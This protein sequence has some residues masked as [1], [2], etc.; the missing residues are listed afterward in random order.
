MKKRILALALAA[1]TAFSMFGASLSV[2]AAEA[3]NA[4]VA[5][6]ID[7]SKY[8]ET[9]GKDTYAVYDE[10]I[11]DMEA[12][13]A[14][15]VE[16]ET[17]AVD[18]TKYIYSYDYISSSWTSFQNALDAALEANADTSFAYVAV[19]TNLAEAVKTAATGLKVDTGSGYDASSLRISLLKSY[20]AAKTAVNGL[21][22]DDYDAATQKALAT[23]KDLFAGASTAKRN[24][25]LVYAVAEY[26]NFVENAGLA[27]IN[28]DLYTAIDALI[29]KAEKVLEYRD[30]YK[31]T[32][33]ANR[34]FATLEKKLEA[35]YEVSGDYSVTNSKL[36]TVKE[37]L[38]AALTAVARYGTAAS[39]ATRDALAAAIAKAD[40]CKADSGYVTTGTS[41]AAKA[42][43]DA[44]DA[45]KAITSAD[46]EH[47]VAD[48]TDA[49]LDAIANLKVNAA[50]GS[51]V[52]AAQ[53]K[54][55]EAGMFDLVETDYTPSSWANYEDAM[56]QY[57][58]AVTKA[59][60]DAA[61]ARLLNETGA[62]KPVKL[63]KVSTRVQKNEF[64][65][66]YKEATA[67][68]KDTKDKSLAAVNSFN[69]AVKAAETFKTAKLNSATVSE[70]EAQISA[71]EAAIKAYKENKVVA[72]YEGWAYDKGVWTFYVKGEAV[73]G[74]N[75][76]DN[77]WYYM[78]DKGVMQTGWVKVDGAWY[79]LKDW[80][81]MA[82]GWAQVKGTWYFL[83]A[84]GKCVMNTWKE[85]N[86]KWYYFNASGA[87]AVNTTI[88]GYKVD[89]NGV[90][91]K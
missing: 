21:K 89:A 74:W 70:I 69:A 8:S 24:S 52:L 45:A 40:A 12:V 65:A 19:Y 53:E 7:T 87:M 78:N 3:E 48:A 43:N 16:D 1:A 31:T 64:N 18:S 33:A 42:F 13:R 20:D 58:E 14:L 23:V 66:V 55:E 39:K 4:K 11:E 17:E 63:V 41:D 36:T 72:A 22:A 57:E 54:L 28:D 81:G 84:S 25:E 37:E 29:A 75:K 68:Q 5:A 82:T 83:D 32:T 6:L 85:I 49:L 34:A 91:V 56:A 60:L 35:A 10:F 80:G 90:W 47:V 71:L 73:T 30:E 86:G 46:T 51:Q 67:L 61:V 77:V 88:N 50:K 44:Y 27:D 9:V 79:Y 76:I 38:D 62:K 59:E 2:S 26:E 15:I